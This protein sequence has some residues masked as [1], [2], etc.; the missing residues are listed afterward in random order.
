VVSTA[1]GDE[2]TQDMDDPSAGSDPDDARSPVAADD[3]EPGEDQPADAGAGGQARRWVRMVACGLL[4]TVAFLLAG[5]AGYLKWQGDSARDA[6]AAQGQSVA[7]AAEGT[8]ALL[9]YQAGS[10]DKQLTAARDRLTGTFR[11]SYGAL[12]HDVII[13]GA[14]QKQISAVATVPAAASVSAT[15]DHAVV[16]VFVDQL[17]TVGADAP[18]TTAS[19]VKVTL[20]RIG[21][22]WLI[23]DFTPV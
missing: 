10:V 17:V 1:V 7:A 5:G 9:S 15:S 13:P 19:S 11:D 2:T 22:R 4:P 3:F 21:G 23:S 20:D 12:I 6:V 8:I 14:Q 16:L 18:T